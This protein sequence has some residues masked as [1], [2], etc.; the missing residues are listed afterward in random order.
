[1]A[2]GKKAVPIRKRTIAWVS[3]VV[4]GVAMYSVFEPI[5]TAAPARETIRIRGEIAAII[6]QRATAPAKSSLEQVRAE[7]AEL[8]A[9]ISALHA[10]YQSK[11]ELEAEFKVRRFSATVIGLVAGVGCFTL[12]GVYWLG[13]GASEASA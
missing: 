13:R 10:L 1:M 2:K 9:T 6:P 12:C 11:A 8:R 4:L 5:L 7:V 3:S